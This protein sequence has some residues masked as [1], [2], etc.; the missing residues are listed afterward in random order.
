MH[1]A[2]QSCTLVSEVHKNAKIQVLCSSWTFASTVEFFRAF[3]LHCA[4]TR[5]GIRSV[6]EWAAICTLLQ[7][8]LEAWQPSLQRL[9]AKLVKP[10]CYFTRLS[11]GWSSWK[12][13]VVWHNWRHRFL[14]RCCEKHCTWLTLHLQAARGSGEARNVSRHC[15]LTVTVI[16]TWNLHSRFYYLLTR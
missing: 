10:V 1:S 13:L 15:L 7:H 5:R 14:P 2:I 4:V 9:A 8:P 6:W 12:N 11:F 16:W 3:L